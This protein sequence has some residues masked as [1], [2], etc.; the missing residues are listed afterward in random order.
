MHPKLHLILYLVHYIWPGPWAKLVHYMGNRGPFGT[1]PLPVSGGSLMRGHCEPNHTLSALPSLS[2][3]LCLFIL[4]A[5]EPSG[6]GCFHISSNT[7][8]VLCSGHRLIWYRQWL[9]YSCRHS[10]RRHIPVGYCVWNTFCV[11]WFI[12]T[13]VGSCILPSIYSAG[14]TQSQIDQIFLSRDL[15]T[16]YLMNILSMVVWCINTQRMSW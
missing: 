6:K 8:I 4:S 14:G 13:A 12:Q 2:D 9:V 3:W 5:Y 15:K 11:V 1:H 16:K 10:I 7:A